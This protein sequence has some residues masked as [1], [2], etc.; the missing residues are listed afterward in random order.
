MSE[1]IAFYLIDLIFWI[2]VLSYGG[3]KIFLVRLLCMP[4][5]Y[6]FKFKFKEEVEVIRGIALLTIIGHTII[7]F[8]GLGSEDF[9]QEIHHFLF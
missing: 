3:A 5:A 2:W 8:I 6:F 4:I 1:W 9:R 7:F